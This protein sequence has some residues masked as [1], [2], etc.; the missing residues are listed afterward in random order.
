MAK[1]E[2]LGN[3][4]AAS[5]GGYTV[6][7]RSIRPLRVAQSPWKMGVRERASRGAGLEVRRCGRLE[8]GPAMYQQH[9]GEGSCGRGGRRS[10]AVRHGNEGS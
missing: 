4:R 7:G 8:F 3:G 10:F 9:G 2:G 6:F 5:T 1:E